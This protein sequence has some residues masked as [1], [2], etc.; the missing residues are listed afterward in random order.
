[1]A[2]T[3]DSPTPS[4][5][6]VLRVDR[7]G[8][9]LRP[10]TRELVS[11]ATPLPPDGGWRPSNGSIPGRRLCLPQDGTPESPCEPCARFGAGRVLEWEGGDAET[12]IGRR[13]PPPLG[14]RGGR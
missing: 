7:R 2:S 11:L 14:R 12:T 10:I 4:R 6:S 13:P 9:D 1:M 5:I 8:P 3:T